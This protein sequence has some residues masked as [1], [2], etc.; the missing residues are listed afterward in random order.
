MTLKELKEEINKIDDNLLG[1]NVFIL[2]KGK[3]ALLL[4][5]TLHFAKIEDEQ[6]SKNVAILNTDSV[7]D[8][9]FDRSKQMYYEEPFKEEKEEQ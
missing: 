4:I 9:E 8:I 7:E 2:D 1:S 5:K 3:N 6:T